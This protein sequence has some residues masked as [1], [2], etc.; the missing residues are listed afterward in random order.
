MAALN[1]A[2]VDAIADINP[3]QAEELKRVFGDVMAAVV[4]EL[5]NPAIQAF[6]ELDP[7]DATWRAV[8]KAR[9]AARIK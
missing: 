4:D 3:E 1:D 9:A 2:L 7:D 6:P 8:A 5:I